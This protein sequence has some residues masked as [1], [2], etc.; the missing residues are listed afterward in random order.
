MYAIEEKSVIRQVMEDAT[1]VRDL[2]LMNK[3]EAIE[4]IRVGDWE[5]YQKLYMGILLKI[6]E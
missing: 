5:E 3:S 4:K 1:V 6:L 2:L